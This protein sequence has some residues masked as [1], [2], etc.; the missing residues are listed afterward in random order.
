MEVR[1][2]FLLKVKNKSRSRWI[3]HIIKSQIGVNTAIVDFD[4]RLLQVNYNRELITIQYMR[5]LVRS[6]GCDMLCDDKEIECRQNQLSNFLI[7]KKRVLFISFLFFLSFFGLIFPYRDWIISLLSSFIYFLFLLLFI[8][9]FNKN[10][11][12]HVKLLDAIGI[13]VP[14][15]LII[16]AGLGMF[17]FHDQ[18]HLFYLIASI[19]LIELITLFR[20]NKEKNMAVNS[21]L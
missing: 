21:L 4:K 18:L 11:V 16:N 17:V 5:M 13:A 12:R 8:P 19:L 15:L 14:L 9:V 2:F 6:L 1:T 20:W 3:E 10:V 7:L